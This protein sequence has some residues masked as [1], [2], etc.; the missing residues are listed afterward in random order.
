MHFQDL[1]QRSQG[2]WRCTNLVGSQL[3]QMTHNSDE[4][5]QYQVDAHPLSQTEHASS[6]HAQSASTGNASLRNG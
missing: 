4:S 5:G 3:A 2:D 1:V 6:C